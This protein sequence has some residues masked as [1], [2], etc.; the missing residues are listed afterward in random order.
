MH[1]LSKIHYS[2]EFYFRYRINLLLVPLIQKYRLINQSLF[3][4]YLLFFLFNN[5]GYVKS[6]YYFLVPHLLIIKLCYYFINPNPIVN[7]VRI[8]LVTN[9]LK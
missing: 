7:F 3:N 9:N 5:H 1:L 8:N 6:I 2:I 4:L